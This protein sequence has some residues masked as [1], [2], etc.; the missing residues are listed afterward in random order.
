[1]GFGQNIADDIE[2]TGKE[3]IE[4]NWQ[5]PA[6]V[7]T[8]TLAKMAAGAALA[9]PFG[10]LAGLV[11]GIA[12]A[13]TIA[14][15]LAHEI[16]PPNI[17][18]STTT[19]PDGEL[20]LDEDQVGEQTYILLSPTLSPGIEAT[21]QQLISFPAMITRTIP[22]SDPSYVWVNRDKELFWPT[23]DGK[24]S[25][26]FLG[27]WGVRCNSDPFSRRA[28]DVLPDFRMEIIRNLIPHLP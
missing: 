5:V 25:K 16:E 17:N 23:H 7:I 28:G 18:P 12:E 4:S 2:K 15:A 1:M 3:I 9:G 8:V 26:G 24:A 21:V 14:E 19:P 6:G 13:G 11:G 10:A 22:W 27:R 20:E